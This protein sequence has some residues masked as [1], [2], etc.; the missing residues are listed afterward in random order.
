VG[1][2]SVDS[3]AETSGLLTGFHHI[4]AIGNEVADRWL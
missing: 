3:G 1:M 2:L 4:G